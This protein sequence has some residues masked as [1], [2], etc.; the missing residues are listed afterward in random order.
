[1]TV[2][3]RGRTPALRDLNV[4]VTWDVPAGRGV[5][6]RLSLELL[7]VASA[8]RPVTLDQLHYAALG[9]NGAQSAPNPDYLMP[10]RYQPPMMVRLGGTIGL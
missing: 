7:H 10:T 6:P 9:A 5:V 1:M 2:C 8:R 4:R 3:P